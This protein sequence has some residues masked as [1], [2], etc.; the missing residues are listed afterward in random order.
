MVES[1]FRCVDMA[2]DQFCCDGVGLMYG[3]KGEGVLV[4]L[5]S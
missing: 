2:R 4:Y 3:C 1:V 5:G